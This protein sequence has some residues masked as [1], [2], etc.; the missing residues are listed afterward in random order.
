MY[1]KIGVMSTNEMRS[2]EACAS[3]LRQLIRIGP[4]QDDHAA[5]DFAEVLVKQLTASVLQGSNEERAAKQLIGELRNFFLD[6]QS[7]SHVVIERK[8]MD[9]TRRIELLKQNVARYG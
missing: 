4:R 8:R 6:P 3:Q 5:A 2:L 1:W 7:L 9:L